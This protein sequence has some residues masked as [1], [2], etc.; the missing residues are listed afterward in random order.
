M[1]DFVEK[2][3]GKLPDWLSQN[4]EFRESLK[5]RLK[6][7]KIELFQ[8]LSKSSY[9]RS[10]EEKQAIIKYLKGIQALE[11]LDYEMYLQLGDELTAVRLL[12]NSYLF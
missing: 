8:I 6:M 2:N 1:V 12:K 10:V 7:Q 4:S 11:G 3:L 9:K 5:H